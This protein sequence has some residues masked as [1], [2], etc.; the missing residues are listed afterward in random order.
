MENELINSLNSI[1][2]IDGRYQNNI[3]TLSRYFSEKALIQYR[4][5]IEIE[6]FISL[7]E[8]PLPEL[9]SFPTKLIKDLKNIY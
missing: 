2:P 8:I 4:L 3:K 7:V 5:I 1:S 6:Y 9:K